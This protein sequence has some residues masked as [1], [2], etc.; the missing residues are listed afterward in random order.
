[1][2]YYIPEIGYNTTGHRPFW[3]FSPCPSTSEYGL[4]ATRLTIEL[5]TILLG[6]LGIHD[7]PG[8]FQFNQCQDDEL[9]DDEHPDDE[10]QGLS[11]W[12]PPRHPPYLPQ[13]LSPAHRRLNQHRHRLVLACPSMTKK[14]TKKPTQD[15][16]LDRRAQAA[17]EYRQ[18]N[19]QAVNERAK[20][21]MRERREQLK[22]AP[23]AVQLEHSLR[24][25]QYRRNYLE[26]TK[27]AVKN[28][29]P[30]VP[31][32]KAPPPTPVTPPRIRQSSVTKL[33]AASTAVAHKTPAKPKAK[34]DAALRAFPCTPTPRTL[35]DIAASLSEDDDGGEEEDED[36]EGWDADTEREDKRALLNPTGH[37]DH[38]PQ[39]GQQP[40]MRDG[41]YLLFF[42]FGAPDEVFILNRLGTSKG[43]WYLGTIVR[44]VKRGTVTGKESRQE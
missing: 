9:Q 33:P 14:Q 4:R 5:R 30:K 3:V 27:Q 36:S 40:Y 11:S 23:N 34:P 42:V 38:V 6:S 29:L 44:E 32:K 22:T 26:R 18:R 7:Q 17:W 10:L 43:E 16:I 31:K 13:L 1:Y 2:F 28:S 41:H 25:A 24:A 39:P 20:I 12:S 19:R 21:R 15:E 35:A 37:P 8:T